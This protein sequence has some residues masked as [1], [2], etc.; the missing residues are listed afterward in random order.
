MTESVGLLVIYLGAV[1]LIAVVAFTAW[2]L[3]TPPKQ[4]HDEDRGL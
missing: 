1:V 4:E 3:A 2:Y